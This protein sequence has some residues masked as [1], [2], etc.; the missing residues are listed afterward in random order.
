MNEEIGKTRD[1]KKKI[2]FIL[3]SLVLSL[4][5]VNLAFATLNDVAIYRPG[6]QGGM[7]SL[8][9][10][11]CADYIHANINTGSKTVFAGY[12]QGTVASLLA[13]MNDRQ[14]DGKQDVLVIIDTC[15]GSLFHGET[16]ESIAEEWMEN[17]NTL[18]WTGSEPFAA[19]VDMNGTVLNDGAG[20]EG[21]SKILDASSQVFVRAADCKSR[22][23]QSGIMMMPM[24]IIIS[25]HFSPTMQRIHLIT[26]NCSQT[27]SLQTGT[28]CRTGVSTRFLPKIVKNTSPTT[29]SL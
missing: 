13:W 22:R 1:V 19:Y 24:V 16:D 4:G 23:P 11:A 7:T 28:I 9:Q 15:P 18:I 27:R 26:V 25:A 12:D 29:S 17:G 3:T 2:F 21:A 14:N 6:I 20:A 5:L 10:Q 8:E